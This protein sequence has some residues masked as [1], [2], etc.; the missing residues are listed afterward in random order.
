MTLF[1]NLPPLEPKKGHEQDGGGI[2][3]NDADTVPDRNRSDTGQHSQSGHSSTTVTRSWALPEFVPNLRR[4][5]K[6]AK[7][8]APPPISRGLPATPSN[9]ERRL[10]SP[11][12]PHSLPQN[13]EQL[14]SKWK[15]AKD[16]DEALLEQTIPSAVVSKTTRLPRSLAEYLPV[17]RKM[18]K[19]KHHGVGGV[20]RQPGMFDPF[21]EY[22]PIAPND[23]QAYKEWI[24]GEKQ[25]RAE[26]KKSILQSGT[27]E[28]G[29]YSPD[30]SGDSGSDNNNEDE[31]V[32][33]DPGRPSVRVVLTN[34]ADEIDEDLERE[35]ME[36]CSTFG[37]VVK[38]V[39]ETTTVC[40]GGSDMHESRFERVR[41]VVEFAELDAA[42]HAQEAL[43]RR[44]FDGRHISATFSA[45]DAE[46]SGQE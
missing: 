42:V 1:G 13:P 36:E 11:K 22:N 31:R 25:R 20:S 3:A 15:A 35:T 40:A 39:A 30:R 37:E 27:Y 18:Q 24:V 46:V 19:P 34:M 43:D 33:R 21:E 6:T 8:V 4:P 44:F 10:L 32:N 5:H 7:T 16:A 29:N 2:D 26:R 12:H 38:C 41:V 17:A 9:K 23:Y 14:I 28:S 45:L